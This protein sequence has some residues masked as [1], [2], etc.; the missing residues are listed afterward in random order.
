[1]TENAA[2][3]T[4]P[5]K[6][7]ATIQSLLANTDVQKRFNEILGKK[8]AG[9]ISSIISATKT[10]SSLAQCD[11]G[12]VLSS[13]IVAATL[14]L[15]INQNLGFA[16]I[17]PYKGVA[18]FQ[19]MWRGYVQLGIRTG[20]YSTMNVS[21]VYEGQL[22]SWNPLTG[23]FVGDPAAKTS[24]KKIGYLA[25]FKL[26][27]GFEKYLYMTVEEC[28]AHGKKYSQSFDNP[29][30]KWK[31]DEEAMCLK[32]VIKRLLSKWGILSIELQKAMTVDQAVIKGDG[33]EETITY[34][35]AINTEAI[36]AEDDDMPKRASQAAAPAPAPAYGREAEIY[37]GHLSQIREIKKGGPW[38]VIDVEACSYVT[39]NQTFAAKLKDAVTGKSLV[40]IAFLNV[41]GQN[42]IGLVEA[43]PGK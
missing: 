40:K 33:D 7:P 13:A 5:A 39:N 1:M 15:P 21:P 41:N 37:T 19:M 30:G 10:N 24:D 16:A 20:Q 34:P 3:S 35:D 31:L 27:N 26:I 32:T 6:R 8:S 25:Y 2:T 22:K 4:A 42:E 12:T 17:V 14:D 18:Q 28:L 23:E 36:S 11:P 38:E 29:K 9:F 43:V